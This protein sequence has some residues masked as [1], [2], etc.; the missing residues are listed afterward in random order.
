[1]EQIKLAILGWFVGSGVAAHILI[2]I[3]MIK[4][5]IRK[6]KRGKKSETNK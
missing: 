6:R 1:M 5:I 3:N 4:L 2:I